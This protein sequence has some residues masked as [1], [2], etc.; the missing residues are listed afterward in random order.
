M[1]L[2]GLNP[3]DEDLRSLAGLGDRRFLERALAGETA[4]P[5]FDEALKAHELA[6]A[7]YRSA[8]A[9]ARVAVASAA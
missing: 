4:S 9:R 5:S 8:A 7:C 1:A 3:A 6:D 2:E